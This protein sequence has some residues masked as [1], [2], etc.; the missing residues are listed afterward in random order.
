MSSTESN[1]PLPPKSSPICRRARGQK[2]NYLRSHLDLQRALQ[3]LLTNF[4]SVHD[5]ARRRAIVIL[6]LEGS[7]CR[8][9]VSPTG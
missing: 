1:A 3:I 2:L 6:P 4:D 8:S 9:A 5:D 7:L